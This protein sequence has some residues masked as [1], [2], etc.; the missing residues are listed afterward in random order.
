MIRPRLRALWENVIG[1]LFVRKSKHNSKRVY[2]EYNSFSFNAISDHVRQH[3]R[4]T[5][6]NLY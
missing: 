3:I 4:A 1:T 2:T 5:T 6:P